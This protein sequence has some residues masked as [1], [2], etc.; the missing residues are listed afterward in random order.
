MLT[1]VAFDGWPAPAGGV[2]LAAILLPAWIAL[3]RFRY[4]TDRASAKASEAAVGL[5]IVGSHLVL[6]IMVVIARGA[7][8][9]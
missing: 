5:A 7:A 8:R 3:L 2:L 1:W 4:R 9:A 6:V